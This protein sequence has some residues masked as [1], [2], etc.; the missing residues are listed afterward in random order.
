M[1]FYSFVPNLVGTLTGTLVGALTTWYTTRSALT[2]Q[3][4]LEKQ[5]VQLEDDKT[6]FNALVVLKYELVNNLFFLDNIRTHMNQNFSDNHTS[7]DL[8]FLKYNI[9][10][11]CNTELINHIAFE[12]FETLSFFYIRL[13]SLIYSN[14]PDMKTLDQMIEEGSECKDLVN[15]NIEI[16]REKLEK[17]NS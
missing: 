3:H 8:S 12:T 6:A 1:D 13:S 9:W 16:L 10:H 5:R 2:K 14:R 17:L 7:Y 11:A 15:K 4:N